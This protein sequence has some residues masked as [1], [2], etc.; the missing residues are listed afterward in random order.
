MDTATKIL[1]ELSA[2]VDS[3]GSV[4][5]FVEASNRFYTM[6]P[7]TFGIQK[8]PPV[9]NTAKLIAEKMEMLKHLANIKLTYGI[10]NDT[11]ENTNPFDHLYHKLNADIKS[12]YYGNDR[13]YVWCTVYSYAM[14]IP[15]SVCVFFR[16]A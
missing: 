13:S 8:P 16:S 9:I 4:N 2:M 3:N 7:H 11:D 1:G 6:V 14:N 15:M 10:L 5:Q 12:L